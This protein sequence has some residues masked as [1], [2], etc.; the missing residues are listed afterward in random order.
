MDFLQ[1]LVIDFGQAAFSPLTAAFII[2]AIGLNVHFGFTGLLNF[3]QAAFMLVG[4]YGFA[5]SQKFG[6]PLW[7][8]VI[9]AM[10][11]AAIFALI[12]GLPAL[13]LRGDYL[14]IVTIA[15]AEI[16]RIVGANSVLQPITGGVLGVARSSYAK[17]FESLSPF[18][19]GIARIG[20]YA[21]PWTAGGDSIWLRVVGFGL[22][23]LFALLVWLVTRGPWGRVLKAIREDEDAARSLGKNVYARKLQALVVGGVVGGFGGIIYALS[24]SVQPD[25]LGRTTTYL[26]WTCLLLGGAATVFGP[27][28]GSVIYFVGRIAIQ[29]LARQFIPPEIMNSQQVPQFTWILVGVGLMLIVIF[30]PQGILGNRKEMAFE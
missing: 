15:A 13:R 8:A 21:K 2:A 6:A 12:L 24:A 30:R 20:P 28:L 29:D 3:G 19:D 5:I 26:I 10:I 7:A 11:A 1:S 18:G 14:A 23:I 4:A 17:E 27:I 25:S 22:V 9:I 16:V